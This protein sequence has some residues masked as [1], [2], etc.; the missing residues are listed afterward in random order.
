[1]AGVTC[2][3]GAG[4][5]VPVWILGSSLFGAS[6]AAHLGLP[7]AFASHFAPD[8]LV[9][10][11]SLYRRE[12]RPSQHLEQPRAMAAVNVI[13][14]DTDDDAEQ[15]LT[16]AARWRVQR[17]L[18]LPS[19]LDD[20]QL[21]RVI[22]SPQGQQIVRMMTYRAVGSPSTVHRYLDGFAEHAGADELI[23]A[24]ASPTTE[25]RVRS[26]ELVMAAV[27]V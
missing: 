12:F 10:A 16:V 23:V 18:N 11:M 9:Q 1:V 20:D 25:E 4:T 3:P 15:Q 17:F 21:D 6:L 2:V 24:L 26:L 5:D 13:C 22:A 19:D 14:A 8:A 7:F 27:A